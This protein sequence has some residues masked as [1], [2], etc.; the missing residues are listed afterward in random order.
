MS[1]SGIIKKKWGFMANFGLGMT[2]A[3][4]AMF[5]TIFFV[6]D[7]R[8]MRPPEV[9]AM[10]AKKKAYDAALALEQWQKAGK[11]VRSVRGVT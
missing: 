7:S 10:E 5:Y 2:G 9:I 3:L 1:C 8:K 11:K 4:V 6:K